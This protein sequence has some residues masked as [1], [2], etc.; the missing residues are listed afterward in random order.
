MTVKR[1]ELILTI[2]KYIRKRMEWDNTT[3]L[4][5][6]IYS[7]VNKHGRNSQTNRFN[8]NLLKEVKAYFKDELK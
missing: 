4:S 3:P 5:S 8:N 6:I 2:V 1:S 7:E